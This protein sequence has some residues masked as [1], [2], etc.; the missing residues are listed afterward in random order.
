MVTDRLPMKLAASNGVKVK[1]YNVMRAIWRGI[2]K[3][4]AGNFDQGRLVRRDRQSVAKLAGYISKY[5]VKA[6]EEGEA[7][8]NR[9]SASMEGAEVPDAIKME[10]NKADLADVIS[11][12]Y[13]DIA[14]GDCQITAWLSPYRDTFY[15]AVEPAQLDL[16]AHCRAF[17]K[18]NLIARTVS[19]FSPGLN[20]HTISADIPR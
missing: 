9:Y 3:E 12:A 16:S 11:L 4:L 14:S 5:L 18:A 17:D 10:F 19:L 6:F 8:S 2:T 15:L 13:G 20:P 7:W 1:S